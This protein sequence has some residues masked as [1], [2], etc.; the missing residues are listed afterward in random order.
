MG[1]G[2]LNLEGNEKDKAKQQSYIDELHKI[3]REIRNI[4]H[5]LKNDVLLSKQDY[6]TLIKALIKEQS[7]AGN[8]KYNITTIEEEFWNGSSDIIKINSY[9]IIQESLLNITKHANA[10]QVN[11]TLGYTNENLNFTIEDNGVGFND[12][13]TSKGIGISNI[14]SRIKTINGTY[15]LVSPKNKG[16][17]T[18]VL[19]PFKTKTN[20]TD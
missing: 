10:T 19:I 3:E 6:I 5:E 13:K 16:T 14:N 1:L 18:T 9:R 15:S 7:I 4:S 17:K 8:F 12:K 2:F 20:E 11:I